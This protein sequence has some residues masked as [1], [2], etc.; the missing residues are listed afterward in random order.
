MSCE[1]TLVVVIESER[2][3]LARVELRRR[4]ELFQTL[5]SIIL[6]EKQEACTI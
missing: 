2:S 1:P 3:H 6:F 5:E 4:R